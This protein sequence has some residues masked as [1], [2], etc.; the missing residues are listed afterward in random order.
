MGNYACERKTK[1]QSDEKQKLP[2]GGG[3]L[4]QSH[5]VLILNT[6]TWTCICSLNLPTLTQKIQAN[7]KSKPCD[8]FHIFLRKVCSKRLYFDTRVSCFLQSPNFKSSAQCF[9]TRW[10]VR[11]HFANRFFRTV[12]LKMNQLLYS[13]YV[14]R[15]HSCADVAIICV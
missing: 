11:F 5:R 7:M 12:R 15:R 4:L 13:L 14:I 10:F 2:G 3:G 8:F 6:C 1:E 9:L